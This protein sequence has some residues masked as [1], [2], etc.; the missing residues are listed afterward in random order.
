MSRQKEID[1]TE[2]P[3]YQQFTFQKWEFDNA[4]R[5]SLHFT[6]Q[7]RYMVDRKNEESCLYRR[8][9]GPLMTI[10][11]VFEHDGHPLFQVY[12][13]RFTEYGEF[14]KKSEDLYETLADAE[15]AGTALFRSH[16]GPQCQGLEHPPIRSL[17]NRN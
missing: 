9:S 12:V 13:T 11:G 8:A 17:W 2:F 3:R 14:T 4:Q 1:R 16:N 5:W 15:S 6:F 7:E 10:V